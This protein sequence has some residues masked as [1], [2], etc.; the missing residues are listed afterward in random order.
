MDSEGFSFAVDDAGPDVVVRVEG[1]L[2]MATAPQLDQCLAYLGAKSLTL[3]LTAL[4]FMDS[5]GIA[6]IVKAAKR[7]AEH[8]TSFAVRGVQPIQRRLFEITGLAEL[9]NG[10][11][12]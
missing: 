11:D 4:T 6:I 2:D 5:G 7:A 10:E 12:E 1:E 3:D 9:L 8:D